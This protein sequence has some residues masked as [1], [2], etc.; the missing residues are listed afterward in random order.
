MSCKKVFIRDGS[1]LFNFQTHKLKVVYNKIN[2]Y[3]GVYKV[4]GNPNKVKPYFINNTQFNKKG[5]FRD[6]YQK[7]HYINHILCGN[8]NKYDKDNQDDKEKSYYVN[9]LFNDYILSCVEPGT[10][11]KNWSNSDG[12]TEGYFIK[13]GASNKIDT[14]YY[15]NDNKIFIGW[16]K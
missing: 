15:F 1:K 13:Y 9:N 11:E 10:F 4:G 6:V 8:F 5:V 12:K 14:Y 2:G 16:F 7:F 3:Y